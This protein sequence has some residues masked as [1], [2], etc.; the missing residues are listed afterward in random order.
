MLLDH[1]LEGMLRA[2]RILILPLL[3]ALWGAVPAAA[4]SGNLSG[5]PLCEF[6][7]E[8]IVTARPHNFGEPGVWDAKHHPLGTVIQFG[9]GMPTA[10]GTVMAFGRRLEPGTAKPLETVMVELNPR[11]RAAA[12]TTRPAKTDEAPFAIMRGANDKGYIVASNIR[13]GKRAQLRLAWHDDAAAFQREKMFA[14]DVFDYTGARLIPAPDGRGMM[15]LLNA[16]NHRNDSD[17]HAV[18]LR[19]SYDGAVMWRR[20]YRPGAANWLHD[21]T[22]LPEGGFFAVGS[23]VGDDGRDGGW[24]MKLA[25]D[26]AIT[27][28]RTYP[29]GAG[30]A[31]KHAAVMP[32]DTPGRGMLVALGDALGVDGAPVAAWVMVDGPR[33]RT[34]VAALYPPPGF[35]FTRIGRH[36]GKRRA[37]RYR[38]ECRRGR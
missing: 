34:A 18:L 29:R 36:A 6:H 4:Q 35:R 5:N 21:I 3:A 9:A 16:V 24:A 26:G 17:R 38:P 11:G 28:Q 7:P 2:K 23:M 22:P 8:T 10:N 19:L 31:L 25:H 12:L 32:H 1:R 37:A 13:N 15:A 30:A 33:R 20:A 27:W 14:D